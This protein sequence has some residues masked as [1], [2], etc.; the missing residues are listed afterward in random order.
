MVPKS[1]QTVR[2]AQLRQFHRSNHMLRKALWQMG[3]LGFLYETPS[4]V[5]KQQLNLMSFSETIFDLSHCY[6]VQ[7]SAVRMRR[8]C[9]TVLLLLPSLPVVSPKWRLP[10]LHSDQSWVMLTQHGRSRSQW[11]PPQSW[12]GPFSLLSQL[13]EAAS[14]SHV[15]HWKCALGEP[16]YKLVRI[17]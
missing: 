8:N 15:Q 2:V 11:Q 17:S 14:C 10:W 6:Q 1:S 4:G 12:R 16:N 9:A 7:F 3:Y 5:T 13:W